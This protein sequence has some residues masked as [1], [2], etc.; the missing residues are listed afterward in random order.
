MTREEFMKKYNLTEE[1]L[2][3]ENKEVVAMDDGDPDCEGFEIRFKDES[4][5]FSLGCKCSDT[6]TFHNKL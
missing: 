3:K 4:H 2:A 6:G 1:G 5:T